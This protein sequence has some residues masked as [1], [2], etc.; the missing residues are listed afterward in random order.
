[1]KRTIYDNDL[2]LVEGGCL[3]LFFFLELEYACCLKFLLLLVGCWLVASSKKEKVKLL[4]SNWQ[5][6]NC[7]EEVKRL[8]FFVTDLVLDL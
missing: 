4:Y 2:C 1:M 5:V 7:T 3:C 8:D 6:V